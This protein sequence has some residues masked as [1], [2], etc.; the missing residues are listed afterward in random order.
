MKIV[1]ASNSRSNDDG[2][3]NERKFLIKLANE[4]KEW[5]RFAQMFTRYSVPRPNDHK[6]LSFRGELLDCYYRPLDICGERREAAS[7][8][9][10]FSGQNTGAR[11]IFGI[12]ISILKNSIIEHSSCE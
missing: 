12:C 10:L 6:S 3:E 8:F 1:C 9:W 2:R 11:P 4:I 5:S 7:E